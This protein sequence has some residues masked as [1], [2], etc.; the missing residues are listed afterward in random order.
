MQCSPSD[1]NSESM[2]IARSQ[3]LAKDKMQATLKDP[4]SAKY[5]DVFAHRLANGA[6]IFCGRVN[7]KNGFGGYVGY[8]RFIAAGAA[9]AMENATKDF[10]EGWNMYCADAGTEVAF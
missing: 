8:V 6:Y 1:D 5:Q 4:D 2:Q 3:V 9:V 10:D 7:A